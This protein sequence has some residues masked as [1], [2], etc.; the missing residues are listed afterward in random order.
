MHYQSLSLIFC[1]DKK[2]AISTIFPGI[3]FDI[4]CSADNAKIER[5][6]YLKNRYFNA[7]IVTA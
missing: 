1:P 5:A 6:R 3:K 2:I 4:L 7:Y